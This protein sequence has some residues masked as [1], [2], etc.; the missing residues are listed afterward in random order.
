MRLAAHAGLTTH[1][2]DPVAGRARR[3]GRTLRADAGYRPVDAPH[4]PTVLA[5]ANQAGPRRARSCELRL[6]GNLVRHESRAVAERRRLGKPQRG[7]HLPPTN[8]RLPSPTQDG[9]DPQVVRVHQAMAYQALDKVTLPITCVSLYSRL[10][11]A[12]SPAMSPLSTVELV[13]SAVLSV[14]ET[15]N[16]GA[17]SAEQRSG[18]TSAGRATARRSGP[19]AGT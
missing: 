3:A 9:V 18:R 15:T 17:L 4:R 12:T 2:S 5:G 11:A 13:Q 10:S 14:R 6:A 7:R 19:C 8:S 16:F 1:S